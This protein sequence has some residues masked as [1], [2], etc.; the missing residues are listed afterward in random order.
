[1]RIRVRSATFYFAG[2]SVSVQPAWLLAVGH[3]ETLERLRNLIAFLSPGDCPLGDC[4]PVLEDTDAITKHETL[5][6]TRCND[7]TAYLYAMVT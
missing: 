3:H 5:D 6:T 4:E 7:K 2:S 1:M